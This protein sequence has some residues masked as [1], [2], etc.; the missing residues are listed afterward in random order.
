MLPG[1]R[2]KK[3]SPFANTGVD[4]AGPL[5][6]KDGKGMRKTYIALFT[7]SVTIHLELVGDLSAPTFIQALRKFS[8]R[9]GMPSLMISDNAKTFKVTAKWLKKL[10]LL[11][12]CEDTCRKTE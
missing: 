5:Y 9:R 4:F 11:H 7:C 8:S 6:I 3:S 1:F 2:V 12:K 10:M